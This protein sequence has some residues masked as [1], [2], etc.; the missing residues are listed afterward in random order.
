M[1]KVLSAIR[2]DQ[3]ECYGSLEEEGA[4]E[5]HLWCY[6]GHDCSWVGP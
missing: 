1:S 2:E 3:I 5:D 4:K 6:R